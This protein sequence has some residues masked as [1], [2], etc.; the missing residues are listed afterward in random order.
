M[1]AYRVWLVEWVSAFPDRWDCNVVFYNEAGQELGNNSTVE[2]TSG[3]LIEHMQEYTET[4]QR[5]AGAN[6]V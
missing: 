3:T 1:R 6:Q 2:T 4:L 5:I